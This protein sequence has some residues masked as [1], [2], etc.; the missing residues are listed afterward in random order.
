VLKHIPEPAVRRRTLIL[1]AAVVWALVGAFLSFR[2]ALWFRS[3]GRA[4]SWMVFLAL[5][6]GFLKGHF[7]LSRMAR[8][9]VK[10]IL[11]LSPHK[12]KICIFAFQAIQAYLVIF[13]MMALGIILRHSSVAREALAIVYL[14]IGSA[15]MYASIPYWMVKSAPDRSFP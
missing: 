7:L 1:S 4:V 2:A 13:G 3:S 8:R 10:R 14:A 5:A 6:I 15:L 9:N 11:E 12:E